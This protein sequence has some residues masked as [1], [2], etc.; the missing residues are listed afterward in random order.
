[1]FNLAVTDTHGNL[2][3]EPSL[4]ALARLGR[5]ILPIDR[6][7]MILLPAGSTI[8]MLP[9]REALALRRKG[10]GTKQVRIKTL[11]GE[12]V[13]PASAILP[14]GYTRTL[15][16]AYAPGKGDVPTLPY[17]AFTAMAF[18]KDQPFCG[19]LRTHRDIRWEPG[20]FNSLELPDRIKKL[21]KQFPDN[22][23][24]PHLEKCSL[25][26]RCFTAQNVFYKRWEG[27][28]PTAAVCNASCIGCI[29]ESHNSRVSSPQN[30]IDFVPTVEELTELGVYHLEGSRPIIS[31]G[32]GCEGEP[33]TR[34][35]LIRDAI[36]RIRE[37]TGKGHININT[38]GSLTGVLMELFDA[39]LDMVRISLNSPLREEY[40]KYFKPSGYSY[41]DVV[42][43]IDQS[44]QAG[45][46]VSINLL[47]MPGINDRESQ[48]EAL[49][50]FLR[51]HP[52]N[53]IQ[54]RNLNM[55]PDLYIREMGIPRGKSLGTRGMLRAI[56][57]E[58]PSLLIGNFT[59][60]P[61]EEGNEADPE[62]LGLWTPPR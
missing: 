41:D 19:A 22:R 50:D 28:F 32:Q 34:G 38:N 45:G 6:R 8:A 62:T 43:S 18:R 17:F 54:L 49:L 44:R 35:D 24:I 36:R 42:N 26:Y 40:E 9:G 2:A 48:V 3:G 47:Y 4:E 55:D 15:L 25:K 27:G 37:M 58:F 59:I 57:R 10:K 53:M 60:Y 51:R 20:M 11:D 5:D 23:M 30:R 46:F 33:L 16:P 52:V 13:Y 31:F 56:S 14:P 21:K 1:M 61:E 7:D 29:S 12:Q 39:G